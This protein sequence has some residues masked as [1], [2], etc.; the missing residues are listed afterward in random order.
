MLVRESSD[1]E[2]VSFSPI[3]EIK[4]LSHWS[5]VVFLF[6]ECSFHMPMP[7]VDNEETSIWFMRWFSLCRN[8]TNGRRGHVKI[9]AP[10]VSQICLSFAV[11]WSLCPIDGKMIHKIKSIVINSIPAYRL[12]VM[13]KIVYCYGLYG[14][15]P[16]TKLTY[17]K[18]EIHREIFH[19]C[20]NLFWLEIKISRV[21]TTDPNTPNIS[22]DYS[23][24]HLPRN[25]SST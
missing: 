5:F 12:M 4:N 2:A 13:V 25:C 15:N 18:N 8:K 22:I 6:T 20:D 1:A 19:F 3:C 14:D 7:D 11:H 10:C 9:L 17:G 16:R 21:I 24:F 23:T